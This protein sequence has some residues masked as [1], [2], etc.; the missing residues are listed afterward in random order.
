MADATDSVPFAHGAAGHQGLTSNASGTVLT[1]P[2]TAA[3]IAFYQSASSDP[4]HEAF[5]AH[6]PTFLGSLAPAADQAGLSKLLQGTDGVAPAA[7]PKGDESGEQ[8]QNKSKDA[9]PLGKDEEWTPSGG[10]KIKTGLAIC[11]ANTAS[12]CS[13]PCVLDLKLG[14]RLWDDDAPQAKRQK[15]D[16]VA[17]ETTSGSLGFRVA[18]MKVW[19]GGQQ[20]QQQQRQALS[21][22]E[23]GFV[24]LD[25]GYKS[26][27]KFYGRQFKN[28]Q[29][30][31]AAFETFLPAPDSKYRAEI[32]G[33]FVRELES[34][35]YMLERKESRMYSA[36]VLFVYE[37]DEAALG[38]ALEF[39][40]RNRRADE[41]GQ[42]VDVDVE[43]P[44]GLGKDENDEEIEPKVHD[45]RLIDFAHARWTPGEGPD[46]NALRG[47]R[48]AVEVLRSVLG[49]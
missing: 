6:M 30:V 43:G 4:A 38:R 29:D 1:K 21:K 10:K 12:G 32:G 37:G 46:E 3:E 31:R 17:A 23:E 18:G 44:Q 5:Y 48:S 7:A 19:V 9:V 25:N 2:C 13:K 8:Q 24:T 42:D 33:R 49:L 16:E 45:V 26:Y 47:V 39:E 40:E 20:Q 27:D 14:A 11:L 41:A 34:I 35:I 36:S 22:E 28:A 15:L